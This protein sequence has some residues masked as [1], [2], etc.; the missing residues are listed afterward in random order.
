[1]HHFSQ[2]AGK[3]IN[4]LSRMEIFKEGN[5]SAKCISLEKNCLDI[6]GKHSWP[7]IQP[8]TLAAALQ[9]QNIN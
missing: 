8:Q 3:E 9:S 4:G 7:I 6:S 1:V 2:S 5:G